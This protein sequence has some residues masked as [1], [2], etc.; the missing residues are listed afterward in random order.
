MNQ[1]MHICSKSYYP[2]VYYTSLHVSNTVTAR[3]TLRLSIYRADI[4]TAP[5]GRLH[6]W[7]QHNTSYE[8]YGKII[9]L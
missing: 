2:A 8:I 3:H 4:T 7:P 9:L 1:Q 5:T 6:V